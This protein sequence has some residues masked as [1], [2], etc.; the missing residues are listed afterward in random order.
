[1]QK[2]EFPLPSVL[3]DKDSHKIKF[4]NLKIRAVKVLEDTDI[5][6]DQLNFISLM[7]DEQYFKVILS[8]RLERFHHLFLK[9][10]IDFRNDQ[11]DKFV[12]F[13]KRI[14][15]ILMKLNVSQCHIDEISKLSSRS[16][17]NRYIKK[18]L[19]QHLKQIQSKLEKPEIELNN[20]QRRV[21]FKK[22]K[23]KK[24]NK[25]K[26]EIKLKPKKNPKEYFDETK[27]SIKPIYTPMGNK[28]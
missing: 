23:W 18:E 3:I 11:Y 6:K 27:T 2:K 4:R 12:E 26:A 9:N 14:K 16:K 1:M 20:D 24:K 7:E 17:I 25:N 5:N 22:K 21:N 10:N 13:K 19:S 8:F 28:R 15:E